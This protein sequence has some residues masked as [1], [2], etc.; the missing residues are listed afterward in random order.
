MS[1]FFKSCQ[2]SRSKSDTEIYTMTRSSCSNAASE[3]LLEVYVHDLHI[4][5]V[6]EARSIAGPSHLDG[7]TQKVKSISAPRKTTQ[8]IGPQVNPSKGYVGEHCFIQLVSKENGTVW[9][10]TDKCTSH[11][12]QREVLSWP[13]VHSY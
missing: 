6:I 3:G 13:P 12:G 4:G 9:I 7:V 8:Q 5:Q 11:S 1:L 10:S 2:L